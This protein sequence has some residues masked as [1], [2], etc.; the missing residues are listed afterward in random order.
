[1]YLV[2]ETAVSKWNYLKFDE[3]IH[4]CNLV[5]I[6]LT[7]PEPTMLSAKNNETTQ[8]MHAVK[9]VNDKDFQ[10]KE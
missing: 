4:F 3:I 7:S 8:E 1:M 9:K 2:L 6:L 10:N 5:W